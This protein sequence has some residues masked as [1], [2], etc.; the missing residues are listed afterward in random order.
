VDATRRSWSIGAIAVASAL[1]LVGCSGEMPSQPPAPEREQTRTPPPSE[2]P[3]TEQGSLW[4][5]DGT[6]LLS[7]PVDVGAARAAVRGVDYVVEYTVGPTGDGDDV[8]VP[9]ALTVGGQAI[10]VRVPANSYDGG[11]WLSEPSTVGTLDGSTFEPFVAARPIEGDHPRQAFDATAGSGLAAW[12]ET[13]ITD[14]GTGHWRLFSAGPEARTSLVARAEEVGDGSS[15]VTSAAAVSAGR[16]YWSAGTG[17]QQDVYGRAA[18]GSGVLDVVAT[19]ASQPVATPTG[20]LVLRSEHSDPAMPPGEESIEQLRDGHAEVLLRRVDAP[21]S[22]LAGLAADRDVLAFVTTTPA[23]SGGVLHVV[24]TRGRTARTVA[25]Q[26]SGR[27]ASIA[28]CDGRLQWTEATAEGHDRAVPTYV[29]DTASGDLARIDVD[30]AFRGALCGG[31]HL[32][33]KQLDPA[34]G[35]TSSTVVA[36]WIR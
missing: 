7:E 4:W 14:V 28:L 20:L 11:R 2:R 21:G 6:E 27:E 18:D 34:A 25:L 17:G 12:V 8:V 31:E 16:V 1:A 24:D 19:G 13:D 33:W 10:A 32:A 35:P 29:L 9:L 36:R 26:G 3:A 30:H 5:A 15:S 22:L 23:R